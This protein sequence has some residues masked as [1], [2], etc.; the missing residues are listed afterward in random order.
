MQRKV[1]YQSPSIFSYILAISPSVCQT[2]SLRKTANMSSLKWKGARFFLRHTFRTGIRPS[3]W[4]HGNKRE[5]TPSLLCRFPPLNL[6]VWGSAATKIFGKVRHLLKPCLYLWTTLCRITNE[7]S[8]VELRFD[9]VVA[10]VH[11]LP[12]SSETLKT[13]SS[14]G[15]WPSQPGPSFGDEREERT[16]GGCLRSASYL[17]HL[18]PEVDLLQVDGLGSEV[19]EQMAQEDS[20]PEGLSQVKYLS[21]VPRNPVVSWEHLAVYQPQR[22]LPPVLHHYCDFG[23]ESFRRF[24]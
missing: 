24:L 14:N 3:S 18:R 9:G 15:V 21:R 6:T 19:V 17:W 10:E 4:R 16:I 22:A 13:L 20:I 2:C 23:R 12:K 11:F 1:G 7:G 5:L 8:A